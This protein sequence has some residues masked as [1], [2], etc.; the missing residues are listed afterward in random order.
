MR[1]G[2]QVAVHGRVTAAP[3][4]LGVRTFYLGDETGGVRVYLEPR[5]HALKAFG[6]G[7]PVSAIGRLADYRGE[8]QLVLARPEDA[9]WDGV[10][11]DVPPI[12]V[13]TGAVD[14]AV[15]GRLVRVRGR[16]VTAG[17]AGV[18][19]DDGSGPA[20]VAVLRGAGLARPPVARGRWAVVVGIAGQSASRAP[21]EGGYRVMP[22]GIGDFAA[23][24][25]SGA[26]ARSDASGRGRS[27]TGAARR[28]G[29]RNGAA[30]R[31]P[32][33]PTPAGSAAAGMD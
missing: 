31:W 20:R 28:S 18:T 13:P 24:G 26:A 15:E 22:R 2:T 12:D 8:R 32:W 23:G 3:D 4:V 33:P 25:A 7:E 21:W 17:R 5:D 30:A 14:E 9:W 16:V 19:I 27:L 6:V 1:R 11:G 10:G 29:A